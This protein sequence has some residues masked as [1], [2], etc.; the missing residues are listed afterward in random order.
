MKKTLFSILLLFGALFSETVELNP[1]KECV[2]F[3]GWA[4]L[5]SFQSRL[6]FYNQC[7]KSVYIRACVK[8]RFGDLKLYTSF[9]RVNTYG[10]IR[11]YIDTSSEPE[12]ITFSYDHFMPPPPEPCSEDDEVDTSSF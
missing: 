6:A 11:L 3:K 10:W 2:E 9:Q 1:F 4:P 8:D 12:E 7:F 5:S